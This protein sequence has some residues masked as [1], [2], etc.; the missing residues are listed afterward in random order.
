MYFVHNKL[1]GYEQVLDNHHIIS[2]RKINFC[3]L[4]FCWNTQ[5]GVNN[6]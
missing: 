5:S 1:E 4:F 6:E 2:A 3:W